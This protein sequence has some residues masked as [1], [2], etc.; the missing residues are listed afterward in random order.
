M[1]GRLTRIYDSLPIDAQRTLVESH[2]VKLLDLV[3]EARAKRVLSSAIRLQ[4]RF[5]RIPVLDLKAKEKEINVILDELRRDSKRSLVK[6]PS[7]KD[8]LLAEAID[9]LINWV[10]KIWSVVYEHNTNFLYAHSCLMYAV[11][12]LEEIGS[13]R[14]GCVIIIFFLLFPI[15]NH[16]S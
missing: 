3:P 12:V 16:S 9:S 14:G 5:A 13:S 6:E 4:T 8:E 1:I 15:S 10:N 2:L 7:D 11:K